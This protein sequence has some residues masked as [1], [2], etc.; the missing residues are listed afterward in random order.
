MTV[1]P[2]NTIRSYHAHIYFENAEQRSVAAILRDEI[3][4]RFSVL[5]GSW[6]ELP[7]GPHVRPMY[8]VAFSTAEFPKFVPWLMINRRGLA[9]LVHP[10]TGHP[11]A[12]SAKVYAVLRKEHAPTY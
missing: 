2:L 11:R 3:A 1:Q 12:C 10:N 5:I 8:Q 9:A 4:Q 7:I 6:H